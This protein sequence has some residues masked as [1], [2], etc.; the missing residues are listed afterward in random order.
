MSDVK[1]GVNISD[2]LAQNAHC[3][4][5]GF[6][7]LIIEKRPL[8]PGRIKCSRCNLTIELDTNSQY[9]RIAALPKALQGEFDSNWMKL[10]DLRKY[11]K[12]LYQNKLA[13]GPKRRMQPPT[14]RSALPPAPIPQLELAER[15]PGTTLYANSSPPTGDLE[16]IPLEPPPPV[17]TLAPEPAILKFDEGPVSALASPQPE[18]VAA[19]SSPYA[20]TLFS[21]KGHNGVEGSRLAL[22]PDVMAGNT[23]P[24]TASHDPP[25]GPLEAEFLKQNEKPADWLENTLPGQYVQW[26]CPF[27]KS[28]N[29]PDLSYAYPSPLNACYKVRPPQLVSLTHQ[30]ET[31]V[32]GRAM[33]C[34]LMTDEFKGQFPTKLKGKHTSFKSLPLTLF[35][36]V[37]ILTIL[38][39]LT[40]GGYIMFTTNIITTFLF[41]RWPT[42]DLR[43]QS[44]LVP[45]DTPL[46]TITPQPTL[47]ASQV[48]VLTALPAKL[49]GQ[50]IV[51]G[52]QNQYTI[53]IVLAGETLDLLA[54]IYH[55]SPEAIQK[56]NPML[57]G[58]APQPLMTLVMVPGQ[59]D[60]A[61][62]TPLMAVQN[63]YLVRLQDF[64]NVYQVSESTF[65]IYNHSNSDQLLPDQW[66]ILPRYQNMVTPVP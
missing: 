2:S 61:A 26:I 58:I 64:L 48:A 53:H 6:S 9:V 27:L 14:E 40:A 13:Q 46:A 52:P 43:V 42:P 5:C 36:I 18:L 50:D 20:G 59:R 47:D 49:Y 3:V 55:M 25:K 57:I 62:L 15:A 31:C 66:V 19:G 38:F 21:F 24:G 65:S 56:V 32:S 1:G 8:L 4:L 7:P 33:Y 12:D 39:V 29:D 41:P 11:V 10:Y 34:P 16:E 44:W 30:E 23:M 63:K 35:R 22:S 37:A 54:Q 60:P 17:S 28:E 45:S 51:L